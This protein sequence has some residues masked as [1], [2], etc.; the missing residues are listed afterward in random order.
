[1]GVKVKDEFHLFDT[2]TTVGAVIAIMC[3][4]GAVFIGP[5]NSHPVACESCRG[6]QLGGA[7]NSRPSFLEIQ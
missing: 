3:I 4:L 1:M 6:E 2:L 5:V 7:E